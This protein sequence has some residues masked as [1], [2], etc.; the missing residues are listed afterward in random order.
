V[1]GRRFALAFSVGE[2]GAGEVETG[3][4]EPVS[5]DKFVA[6]MKERFDAREVEE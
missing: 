3:E 4:D 1:T 2:G 5:E 6:L